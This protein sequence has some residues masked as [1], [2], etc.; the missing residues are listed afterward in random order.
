[1]MKAISLA[2]RAECGHRLSYSTRAV[3]GSAARHAFLQVSANMQTNN[4]LRFVQH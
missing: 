4:G 2:P 3:G 1:M